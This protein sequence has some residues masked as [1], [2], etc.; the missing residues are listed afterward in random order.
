MN[1]LGMNLIRICIVLTVTLYGPKTAYGQIMQEESM[2]MYMKANVLYETG[3]YDEAVR[4]YNRIIS[5]DDSFVNAYMMRGKAKYKLGAYKGTKSDLLTYIDRLG[6]TKE[7]IR[8]MIDTE[9]NLENLKAATNYS[10]TAIELDPYDGNLYHQAGLIALDDGRKNDA[11]ESF[12]I[13]A[14]LDH[15]KSSDMFKSKCYGYVVKTPRAPQNDDEEMVE[16][17]SEVASLEDDRD[18]FTEDQGPSVEFEDDNPIDYNAVQ[19]IKVDDNLSI[20][21]AEGLGNRNVEDKPNI[22]ILSTEDGVVIIDV[23]VDSDGKVT[24]ANFNRDESSLFRSSLTS[25]ALRKAKEF[26]FIPS[27]REEQC[28]KLHFK[29][30]A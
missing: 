25:L 22:F 20:E 15:G 8:L 30:K 24:E 29:I 10:N 21:I 13:G 16:K 1:K 2:V 11:C 19:E 5:A 18:I 14:S 6:V 27:L 9:Y 23:C 7:V 3:R 26:I 28:G 12:A 4:M 17:G